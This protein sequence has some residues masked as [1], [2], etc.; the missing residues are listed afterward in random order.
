[1]IIPVGIKENGY[2]ITLSRGALSFAGEILE[3]DRKVLVVTDTGVPSEYS[4]TV[5]S[6]CKTAVRVCLPQGESSKCFENYKLLLSKM[7]E[8]D[9]TRG[10]CVVAVGGGVVGDLCG[11]A[12]SCYMRGIDFYNIPT[13]LL[14]QIDSSIGGKTA[15][16]FDGVKN[17]VGSFYQPKAVLI[18]PNVLKTLEKRQLHSGLAEAIKMSLTS[19]AE[20]FELMEKSCNLDADL[21]EIIERS[22]MIKR[23]VVEKDPQEKGLRRV[24][25]FGHTIG[26]AVESFNGGKLLHGECVA[27]GM[28][29]M[30]SEELKKRV[31]GV[32]RKY[33]LPYSVSESGAQL[34]PYIVHD[35]KMKEGKVT[36]VTV[37]K[38]GEF[39][40][41]ALS[42]EEITQR[43]EK[44]L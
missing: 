40:F 16:D 19:D 4:D 15:I 25:N 7:L 31:T 8:A 43:L 29:P 36:V 13:T 10:D 18:D 28:P 27:I 22:L 12:A 32:L 30:C 14:S 6:M 44:S 20:L 9:F 3:L 1:M 24:L 17:V 11:F 21:D 38:P 5:A 33:D 39:A 35:K 26:H 2:D 42:P 37:Q 41:A 34:L 23:D